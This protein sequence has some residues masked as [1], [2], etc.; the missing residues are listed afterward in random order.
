MVIS[1]LKPSRFSLK[2]NEVGLETKEYGD[3]KIALAVESIPNATYHW[4]VFKRNTDDWMDLP[5]S[6][7]NVH[8]TDPSKPLPGIKYRCLIEING[9]IKKYSR[10]YTIIDTKKESNGSYYS[11]FYQKKESNDSFKEHED[12]YKSNS[13]SNKNYNYEESIYDTDRMT[14]DEFEHY[15]ASVLKR[16]GFS[17]VEVTKV[18]GDYGIDILAKKDGISYAI[19]CKCFSSP[20][21][22]KAIQ[23]AFSGKAFYNAMVAAVL[24][25]NYFTDAAK[26]TAKRTAVLLWDRDYLSALINKKNGSK[27][28]SF[29]T[30]NDKIKHDE[31][32]FF[33]GCTTWEQ[34]KS[35]Y[36]KLM[37]IYHPDNA[38]GNE[39]YTKIIQRQ[40]EE[41]QKKYDK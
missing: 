41:L 37:Q 29:K 24:T 25:N 21:G 5:A 13:E 34:I 39:E 15:C 38:S 9:K 31:L 26:E 10:V 20:V 18:S 22:N 7:S 19:Q 16:N 33:D 17:D 6:Y 36:R 3:G 14:G 35:Q 11:G 1:L 40:Y 30:T 27:D 2:I 8:I 28:D 23:E 4:Q 12:K 32:D